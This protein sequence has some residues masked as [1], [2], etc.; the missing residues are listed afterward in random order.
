MVWGLK[1]KVLP[2]ISSNFV[3]CVRICPYTAT[4]NMEVWVKYVLYPYASCCPWCWNAQD[5]RFVLHAQIYILTT[6]THCT[7]DAVVQLIA[8]WLVRAKYWDSW[9]NGCLGD[10]LDDFW[11]GTLNRISISQE[12]REEKTILTKV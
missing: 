11:G 1:A 7:T 4:W 3:Y 8:V 6:G 9:G 12:M 10:G 2:S 5:V